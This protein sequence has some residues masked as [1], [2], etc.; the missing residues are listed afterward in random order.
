M[1]Q[2]RDVRHFLASAT[3]SFSFRWI[4]LTLVFFLTFSSW[5]FAELEHRS[6]PA[7][8]CDNTTDGG[9]IGFDEVLCDGANDPSLIV[10]LTEA[11]GG[12]GPL[13]YLWLSS[14]SSCPDNLNQA[15]AGA[16]GATY[17]PGVISST[18]WFRR[19]AR[20]S[21]C[22]IWS[23]ESNCVKITVNAICDEC[24]DDTESPVLSGVPSDVFAECDN[25]P[26]VPTVTATDNCVTNPE[27][28]LSQ[29]REPGDCPGEAIL[30]RT[31]T[32]YDDN[33]NVAAATQVITIRDTE[34]PKIF[35]VPVS[36]SVA[37]DEIPPIPIITTLDNCTD[38]EDLIISFEEERVDGDCEYT[39][40][41][42]RIW[43]VADACGNELE[44][45]Q[46]ISV[47]DQKGP[48][49]VNIPQ[50]ITINPANGETVPPPANVIANDNCTNTINVEL[51]ESSEI[52]G[53]QTIITRTWRAT[54]QCGNE[55]SDRQ[56]ITVLCD[57]SCDANAGSLIPN[58]EMYCLIGATVNIGAAQT[59]DP[60]A[61]A[62]Y[63]VI[64]VLTRGTDL[65]IQ[66]AQPTPNFVVSLPDNYTIHTLV[67]D[68]NTLDLGVIDLG[69]TTGLD[70][71]ELLVQGGGDICAALDVLGAP[72]VVS[73]DCGCQNPTIGNVVVRNTSCGNNTG[74]ITIDIVGNNSDYSYEWS[75]IP[76]NL[77][78]VGN[79]QINLPGGEYT[80]T[81]TDGG[82]QTIREIFVGN[83]D[84]PAP[85]TVLSTPA[86]C[87]LSNGTANL[88]PTNLNY[89]WVLDGL[90]TPV[91]S[92][93]TAGTYIV[94]VEDPAQPECINFIE[95][96]VR[97]IQEFNATASV[98][99]EPDCGEGTGV[100]TISVSG[101]S[102]NY[103][104]LWS[105]GVSVNTA[106]RNDLLAGSYGVVITD[107]ATGCADEVLFSI[108]NGNV[109]DAEISI[110]T[111]LAPDCPTNFEGTIDYE[112]IPATGFALPVRVEIKNSE[113]TTVANG[114]LKLGEYCLLVFDA[115][116]CL[117]AS[118]CFALLQPEA[119][120]IHLSVVE[121]ATCEGGGAISLETTTGGD[122]D[123]KYDWADLPGTN[124][125]AS[126][127]NL[128]GG[129]YSLTVTDGLGC[130]A[131]AK[132]IN[133][134][135]PENCNDCE[136]PIITNIVVVEAHCDIAD[137]IATIDL[138]GNSTD[139]RF[140]WIPNVSNT[141][142]ATGLSTGT[143]QVI[144]TDLATE[145]CT[146]TV[147][148]EVG[149]SDGPEVDNIEI[150]AASCL[151]TDG[152]ITLSPLDFTYQWSDNMATNNRDDLAAGTYFVTVTDPDT[153]C[154]NVIAV[155]VPEE[156]SLE[157]DAKVNQQSTCGDNNGSVTILVTGGSGNYNYSW[158][159]DDRRD[160][161]TAGMY[162]VSVIDPAS[163]CG[164]DIMFILDDQLS[165]AT[166]EIE[167]P[168]IQLACVGDNNGTVD[169]TVNP[170]ADFNGVPEIMIVNESGAFVTNGNLS[171]GNYCIMVFD[172]NDCLVT[173]DCFEVL[174]SDLLDI[175]VQTKDESCTS[176]GSLLVFATGGNAPYTFDWADLSGNDNDSAR[177]NLDGGTYDLTVTDASGC[178]AVSQSI[179]IGSPSDCDTCEAPEVVSIVV[180]EASCNN[181]DGDATIQINQNPDNY[182]FTWTPNVSNSSSAN[183]LSAGTYS[184][185][186]TDNQDSDCSTSVEFAVGNTDGPEPTSIEI[187]SATCLAQ[188][189]EVTLL[190]T[191]FTYTWS[192]NQVT[193]S[194][195]GLAA[196]TYFITVNDPSTNCLDVITIVVDSQNGLEASAKIN[197]NPQC[198]ENNGSVTIDVTGGSGNYGYSWGGD[199]TQNNLAAG[200]YN[201]TIADPETGC[202]TELLFALN[203]EVAGVEINIENE[204]NIVTIPC[205]G[206][207][208]GTVDFNVIPDADFA[209]TPQI[210]IVDANG[211]EQI[212]GELGIGDYC[213]LVADNAGCLAAQTC[214]VVEGN[215]L[216]DVDVIALNKTCLVDGSINLV[217]TGG[218]A[219]YT[220]DWADLS[221][222]DNGADRS[223]LLPESYRVT[224]TDSEG[225]NVVVENI[226]IVDTCISTND[227]VTPIVENTVKIAASC[228]QSNG[229][230]FLEMV[231]DNEGFA[232][233][234][235]PNVSDNA[236]A[237]NIPAGVYT[238]T[239][240]RLNDPTCQIITTFAIQNADGP[241]PEIISTTPASCSE[242]N[243]TAVLGPVN[244]QY[245]WCNG[246]N[247]FN[248]NNLPSGSCFVTVTDF[249]TGCLNY[250][251]VVIGTFNPLEVTVNIEDLPSCNDNDG[252]VS[253]DV[254]NG[255]TSYTFAWSD[256]GGGANRNNLTAGLYTV[257][258]T[259]NGTTACEQIT[260]FVLLNEV[261]A[262][263]TI[264]I[265]E[266]PVL[267]TCIGNEDG[268][269]DFTVD[270][271]AG[272]ALPFSTVIYDV[273]GQEVNNGDLGIGEYCMAVTDVNGCF[274]GQNCF[275]VEEPTA[276][277]LD[278]ITQNK[279]CDTTGMIFVTA[280][281]GNGNYTYDWQDI[282]GAMDVADRT[283]LT[284]GA[285]TLIVTDQNGCTAIA[286]N[287]PIL[288]ECS[289]CPNTDIV[290]VNLPV[291]VLTEYCFELESCFDSTDVTYELLGGGFVGTSD[292]GNWTLNDQG[293][294][295][296][297][298]NNISGMGVDTICIIANDNGLP[299]TTCVIISI[300]TDCGIS[301][302]DTLVLPA[303]DCE[304]GAD[305]CLPI[306]IL[307]IDNY[308]VTDNGMFYNGNFVGCQSD[309][310]LVYRFDNFLIDFPLGPYELSGWPVNGGNITVDTF[311]TIAELFTRL[312][313]LD[314]A[315][316]WELENNN[317]VT[318]NIN[319]TYGAMALRS[320]ASS[321]QR[322]IQGE[323][324]IDNDGTQISLDTGFHQIITFNLEEGCVDT[325]NLLI[326]CRDCPGIY[327]G[328]TELI[329]D[330]CEG[331]APIC[332]DLSIS[333]IINY[334]I[335]DNGA[336][337]TG[338]FLGCEIDSLV[339][340]DVTNLFSLN[341]FGIDEWSAL[342]ET[343]SAENLSS[344]QEL[345]DSMNVWFPAGNW[346]LDEFLIIGDNFN[347]NYGPAILTLGGVPIESIQPGLQPIP[348]GLELAIDT[349]FHQVIVED[350]R[351]GC[352]DTIE[353]NVSC[354]ACVED[355]YLGQSQILAAECEDL[356]PIC[357]EL[358]VPQIL[359][360]EVTDNGL[361]YTNG[362]L[363][364]NVDTTV[365]YDGI[366][367]SSSSIYRLNS[368]QINNN[369]FSMGQFSGLNELVD[370]MNVWD[371]T[372]DWILRGFEM[373]GGDLD[374][375]YGDMIVSQFG[376][377][378]DTA[379]PGFNLQPQGAQM[380]L[381]TGMHQIILRD[382]IAGC[383]D[384]FS[385]NILCD[386]FES[387]PT[388]TIP[389]EIL[390]NFTDTF[391]MDTTVLP[392]IIDTIFNICADS[393]GT[394]VN[395]TIDPETYCVSYQGIGI[396]TDPACIVLC[397]DAGH[398]D[399]T[400]LLVTVN[401]PTSESISTEIFFGDVDQFCLDTTELAGNIDT[402]F[403]A[404]PELS[405]NNDLVELVD[406]TWCVI[407]ESVGLGQDT[408]CIVI[409]DDFGVCDTTFFTITNLTL[410]GEG[411]IAV[412][413]DSLTII[414]TPLIID[415]LE[416]DT[417]NGG[418]ISLEI[419]NGPANGTAVVD[420]TNNTFIYTPDR[421]FCGVDS[422][423]YVLN[424][425]TGSDT[426]TVTITI[427]CEEL[428]I[429]NGFS[430]NGDG[431]NDNFIILGIE[432]FP[433]NRVQV[434]NRWG[435]KVYDRQGYTNDD[436]F[437]GRWT[438]KD[439]PDGTYFYLIEDGEGEQYS[440]WLQIHR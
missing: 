9:T 73:T 168:I 334:R 303:F 117:A 362:F 71:N 79:E 371:P 396:G 331:T 20:R 414:N 96:T 98:D 121:A 368:W 227:C 321:D 381:D 173:Q 383:I 123:Y 65:L 55:S 196:G 119:I 4:S 349:G 160:D 24:D 45:I 363:G 155:T 272:F 346:R 341:L 339:Q 228:G 350:L 95:V 217:A 375:I 15:I 356:T 240:S 326:D 365:L 178:I 374:N 338:G 348:N 93:L 347:N 312:S 340:Y 304:T 115:N 360:Y 306:G 34:R 288:D 320:Y 427:L 317:I 222:N 156:N 296:Y 198:G 209:G 103:N 75:T 215:L 392:G 328:P 213:I 94:S 440:G 223:N 143:Y 120:A 152:T 289:D 10:S 332:V 83:T 54:D 84:G 432:R 400:V 136:D 203:D 28:I 163:G 266:N 309:T 16:T 172:A 408:A 101:G 307:E 344:P 114:M 63:N 26:A 263:A 372:G 389:L 87:Q 146:T 269:V 278:I 154:D 7:V 426:A 139:Y 335:T 127:S 330:N 86:T 287:L 355:I 364:C 314:P 12:T 68:P 377:I 248:V 411:P 56:I 380:E 407:F 3:N 207:G 422:F 184:V 177:A 225:C 316:N 276:I 22:N 295:D 212:N 189:G 37:C 124:N 420:P 310:S 270:T 359:N 267:L 308:E 367:F 126:R 262:A 6:H 185:L 72:I 246:L 110:N 180:R 191:D 417:V 42:R 11:S 118:E 319:G 80:V 254:A 234:W 8:E 210:V 268:T 39:Y 153:D 261:G 69:T 148:F 315:G 216:L 434:F 298:S 38:E 224:I 231:G 293:C 243:G 412:D 81:I 229:S 219:P 277:V 370:S 236:F 232:Y 186:I 336:T 247:G 206:D 36:T 35:G 282:P 252:V 391:C 403:N 419:I 187:L 134:P 274:A 188:D 141:A 300:T 386:D 357:L 50:D 399:T 66:D 405:N 149:T 376:V 264:N 241:Q 299:D 393:S 233:S 125:P 358:T 250:V 100:A 199:N 379:E 286:N 204:N 226:E 398:C 378:I 40:T 135:E 435:N 162:S 285:Y 373:I 255:S 292:F 165:T 60:I 174:G 122:G 57:E 112:V 220:F 325:F 147:E 133:V 179:N 238:V 175:D 43:R 221:G 145:T 170:N 273:N 245:E 2:E 53:C 195:G 323:I 281:G 388:D 410:L 17:D 14:T 436:P 107:D 49:L 390:V 182:N 23:T 131:V 202:F 218:V 302:S 433:N 279:T 291:N 439:L 425:S 29:Q 201:I 438:D 18:T 150:S 259:D 351:Q 324:N 157:I 181:N 78:E 76:G 129:D 409:C 200:I 361:P 144:I 130:T 58:P 251:E 382:S 104:F 92:D 140:T 113:N 205:A 301:A 329:A 67:Y 31:W 313:D 208:D 280:T 430:P 249:S 77:N 32:V 106:S 260:S 424:T 211:D 423:Q 99:Q 437:S 333:Q 239:I 421:E 415:V 13:E 47:T 64:Y 176:K 352:I 342:G 1:S 183:N 132:N 271:E 59:I 166:I 21:G 82:C 265:N 275:T 190:P 158:G 284:A 369:F 25:L 33:G 294:L 109:A 19:C 353:L 169:F 431:V 62:G 343:F 429:F 242:S 102:G 5:S 297:T 27:V 322:L 354:R 318:Q 337:Y 416:N 161:L 406:D 366:A 397:D 159:A 290:S 111:N 418:L 428:T 193:N 194:R 51:K 345:V 214:F 404:C 167:N 171:P 30:R 387:L 70:I 237:S 151:A 253:I 61:P 394:N 91:R 105:D 244:Y 142:T 384:T 235:I 311:N 401:P 230:A 41:L 258:V 402:I 164:I 256:G 116:N 46:T 85:T 48:E 74:T 385:V 192:D 52:D 327:S 137:G 138:N 89:T 197:Q 97:S 395:F 88:V 283:D 108:E 257:T 413:D 44:E 128:N 305:F 90:T